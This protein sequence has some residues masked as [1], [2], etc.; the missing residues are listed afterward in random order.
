MASIAQVDPNSAELKQRIDR[1]H[2]V[3]DDIVGQVPRIDEDVEPLAP[4][5]GDFLA[6]EEQ[7][8]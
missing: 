8:T 7:A 4:H 1:F 6:V 2:T 5:A 3:R